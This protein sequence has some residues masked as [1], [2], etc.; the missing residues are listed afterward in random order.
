MSGTCSTYVGSVWWACPGFVGMV[1]GT[2][3]MRRKPSLW[4]LQQRAQKFQCGSMR[5]QSRPLKAP[6]RPRIPQN[7]LRELQQE[8]PGA[9]EQSPRASGAFRGPLGA[10]PGCFGASGALPESQGSALEPLGVVLELPQRNVA[11]SIRRHYR[12]VIR[13]KQPPATIPI[14]SGGTLNAIPPDLPHTPN[15]AP[16]HSQHPFGT[17]HRP[18]AGLSGRA[19]P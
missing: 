7:G 16:Q 17:F 4:K 14:P 3:C 15:S 11:W 5:L 8:P 1:L 2:F 19:L 6:A 9:P 13:C 12:S 10:C 18:P